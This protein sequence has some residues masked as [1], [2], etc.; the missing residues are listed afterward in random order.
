MSICLFFIA[1]RR[2]KK[3]LVHMY[4]QMPSPVNR[5]VINL[6]VSLPIKRDPGIFMDVLVQEHLAFNN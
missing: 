4:T 3:N 1:H 5:Y 2:L 6:V